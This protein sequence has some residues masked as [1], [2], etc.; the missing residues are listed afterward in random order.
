NRLLGKAERCLCLLDFRHPLLDIVQAGGEKFPVL[1]GWHGGGIYCGKRVGGLENS[2]NS[3]IVSPCAAG[4]ERS[5]INL[6][7]YT[8]GIAIIESRGVAVC[9]NRICIVENRL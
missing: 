4:H 7:R 3:G 8:L 1:T 6:C 9:G 5:F 2:R